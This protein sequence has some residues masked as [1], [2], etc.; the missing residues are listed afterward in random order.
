VRIRE[1]LAVL[2]LVA[3]AGSAFAQKGAQGAIAA[4]TFDDGTANDVFG[5]NN[6][7]IHGG[8]TFVEGKVGQAADLDG[9]FGFID[10]PHSESFDALE[11]AMTLTAWVFVRD[12]G[13]SAGIWK[14]E[15][16]EAG[17][18]YLFRIT[19]ADA[20]EVG[21][22]G[23]GGSNV[24]DVEGSF[25]SDEEYQDRW[26]HVALV[27]D[28]DTIQ[29]YVDFEPVDAINSF[30]GIDG[31]HAKKLKGSY[32]IFED[33]PLRMG[34]SQGAAGVINNKTYLNGIID[35]V[36]LW[37]RGLTEKEIQQAAQNLR[38]FLGVSSAGKLATA[39]ATVKAERR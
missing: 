34:M 27:M 2:L 18:N 23:W 7:V 19:Y 39:W 38:L 32:S 24:A 14:G 36:G 9:L 1:F 37:S 25:A 3:S 4:W 16:I 12:T 31:S 35:E 5:R 30:D 22:M 20:N 11:D 6:G 17:A 13:R 26:M 29:A 8:V 28:G 15:L 10:V 21:R 33:E